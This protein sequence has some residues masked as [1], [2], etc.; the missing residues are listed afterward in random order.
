MVFALIILSV[1]VFCLIALL[2][3]CLAN[4]IDSKAKCECA[5]EMLRNKEDVCYRLQALVFDKFNYHV[6]LYDKHLTIEEAKI[7]D[8][9]QATLP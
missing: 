9:K 5:L 1:T 4:L 2:L 6:P 7:Q 3:L 8:A